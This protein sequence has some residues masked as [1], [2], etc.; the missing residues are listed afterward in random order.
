MESCP[1]PRYVYGVFTLEMFLLGGE[2]MS[3]RI[4]VTCAMSQMSAYPPRL[5]ES[6]QKTVVMLRILQPLLELLHWYLPV[7]CS[8][9]WL[10]ILH[11]SEVA[12][13]NRFSPE[14]NISRADTP[15]D[16]LLYVILFFLLRSF[17]TAWYCLI[18]VDGQ[19]F[20]E[21]SIFLKKWSREVLVACT[22]MFLASDIHS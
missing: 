6:A 9:L 16:Q 2:R 1:P 17:T 12:N 10:S 21:G 5:A 22:L 4:E 13:K 14:R 20:F 15:L 18:A 8:P 3:S 19:Y 11:E 7:S